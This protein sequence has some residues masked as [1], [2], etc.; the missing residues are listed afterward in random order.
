[1][2]GGAGV[3]GCEITSGNPADLPSKRGQHLRPCV[4]QLPGTGAA[5]RARTASGCRGPPAG[6]GRDQ[7]RLKGLEGGR[8]R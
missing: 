8:N 7:A 1:M 4:L 6:V 3:S 2:A 5:K